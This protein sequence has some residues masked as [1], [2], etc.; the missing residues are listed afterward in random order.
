M[1]NP[2]SILPLWP[3]PCAGFLLGLAGCFYPWGRPDA[4]HGRGYPLPVEL[5]FKKASS[6]SEFQHAFYPV[7]YLLNPLYGAVGATILGML[8]ILACFM[9]ARIT[10]KR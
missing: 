10:R 3:F 5:W 1:S 6:E 8:L 9:F 4:I 2:R 7:G